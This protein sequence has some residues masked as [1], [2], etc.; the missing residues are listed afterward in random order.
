MYLALRQALYAGVQRGSTDSGRTTLKI[1]GAQ[2]HMT[3]PAVTHG[4][5]ER[6]KPQH[7]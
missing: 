1:E 3:C 4:A 5:D 7:P 6:D 2:R